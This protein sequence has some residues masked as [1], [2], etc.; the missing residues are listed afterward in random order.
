MKA[1]TTGGTENGLKKGG[2]TKG[3]TVPMTR[4]GKAP[5]PS[6]ILQENSQARFFQL[7]TTTV[8]RNQPVPSW[9]GL[10]QA[11]RGRGKRRPAQTRRKPTQRKVKK[12]P[13]L[14]R[15]KFRSMHKALRVYET[16]P[17]ATSE[18]G[19]DRRPSIPACEPTAAAED[20]SRQPEG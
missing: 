5:E 9:S 4:H 12:R 14:T 2:G 19:E 3:L 17:S 1:V 6:Q 10:R 18:G 8:R 20:R 16:A 15:N 7:D 11:P 13:G